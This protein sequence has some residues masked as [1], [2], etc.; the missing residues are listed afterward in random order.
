[1]TPGEVGV[2]AVSMPLPPQATTSP[3]IAAAS[4]AARRLPKPDR[5]DGFSP[6]P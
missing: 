2:G 3:A 1:M 5:E 4:S 6:A